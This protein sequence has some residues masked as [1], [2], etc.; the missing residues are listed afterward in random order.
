MLRSVLKDQKKVTV[1]RFFKLNIK[2]WMWENSFFLGH[3][4]RS[5]TVVGISVQREVITVID[6]TKC[7]RSF[8]DG[9]FL[10]VAFGAVRFHDSQNVLICF[11]H[12]AG[13]R[14]ILTMWHVWH[15]FN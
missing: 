4:R 3:S 13:I 9:H 11:L 5:Y 1:N 12:L 6:I 15:T 10:L 8:S 2:T 14:H 7:Q